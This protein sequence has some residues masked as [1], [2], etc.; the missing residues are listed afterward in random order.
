MRYEVYEVFEKPRGAWGALD[1]KQVEPGPAR[2]GPTCRSLT[3][4]GVGASGPNIV[5]Y[6]FLGGV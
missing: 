4:T 6:F 5:S 1:Y 2:P 3:D